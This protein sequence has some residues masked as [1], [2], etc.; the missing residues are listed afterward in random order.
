VKNV[1]VIPEITLTL[2]LT[3]TQHNLL[4]NTTNPNPM[5]CTKILRTLQREY[6]SSIQCLS[7]QRAGRRDVTTGRR[8]L[9][10]E[11]AGDERGGWA[12]EIAALRGDGIMRG[13][14][15]SSRVLTAAECGRS[16]ALT[17]RPLAAAADPYHRPLIY[18]GVITSLQTHNDY[19]FLPLHIRSAVIA[20]RVGFGIQYRSLA[21][22]RKEPCVLFIRNTRQ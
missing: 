15:R 16:I 18:K 22:N 14:R 21:S 11:P 12:A 19:L 7:S 17:I 6:T 2:T 5:Q 20:S 13:Q 1:R 8:I 9:R 10:I 4:A 3:L